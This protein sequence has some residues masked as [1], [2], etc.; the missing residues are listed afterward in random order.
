MINGK[1]LERIKKNT[2]RVLDDIYNYP[3]VFKYSLDWPGDFPGRTLLAL[4]SLYLIYPRNSVES[5]NIKDR[6]DV[7]FSHIIRIFRSQILLMPYLLFP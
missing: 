5:K 3:S 2:L 7:I 1:L 6:I 4:T